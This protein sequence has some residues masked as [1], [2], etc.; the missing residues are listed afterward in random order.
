MTRLLLDEI[1]ADG[2]RDWL[3]RQ[4]I[5]LQPAKGR[6]ELIRYSYGGTKAVISERPKQGG[7]VLTGKVSFHYPECFTRG[8]T[9]EE[10]YRDAEAVLYTDAS[11]IA[12]T[13]TGSWAGVL[14]LPDGRELETAGPLKGEVVSSSEAE[15]KAVANALHRFLKSGAIKPGSRLKVVCDNASVVHYLE[16]RNPGKSRSP[17]LREAIEIIE[18]LRADHNLA[19]ASEWIKAHQRVGSADPRAKYNRRCDALARQH[20]K[21][22]HATR[23]EQARQGAPLRRRACEQAEAKQETEA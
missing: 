20:S 15:A 6:H 2:F 16:V 13:N 17:G 1:D 11:Q 21:Q 12:M 5:E 8:L 14:V 23:Q 19:V 9:I 3:T 22:L 7:F 10:F 4:G 18:R